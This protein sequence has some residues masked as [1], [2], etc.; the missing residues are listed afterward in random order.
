MFTLISLKKHMQI[1][2][3]FIAPILE[4][5]DLVHYTPP[6]ARYKAISSIRPSAI[7]KGYHV[8]L[9]FRGPT[10]YLFVP[11]KM[12]LAGFIALSGHLVYK[13]SFKEHVLQVYIIR[14]QG[15]W[16]QIYSQP[17]GVSDIDLCTFFYIQ[18]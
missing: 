3:F 4:Q 9:S 2:C 1:T 13:I 7:L 15:V 17:L 8:G 14:L 16:S 5:A 18:Q 12:T 6:M 10:A 11:Q